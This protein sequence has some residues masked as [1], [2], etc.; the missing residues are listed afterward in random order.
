LVA[1][2]AHMLGFERTGNGL[3]QAISQQVEAMIEL[4]QIDGAGDNLQLVSGAAD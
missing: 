1:E 2:V 3:D 4:R